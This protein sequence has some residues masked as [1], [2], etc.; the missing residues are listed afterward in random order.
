MKRIVLLA[1]ALTAFHAAT[2]KE[3]TLVSPDGGI[4]VTVST[5]PELQ[6]SVS[7]RGEPL[8]DASRIGLT[9]AGEAPL[10]V[11]PK[12]RSVRRTS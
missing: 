12:V 2:A 1:A 5:F 7:R 10:G 11:D 3:Y 9:F 6:W 4:E 8:I